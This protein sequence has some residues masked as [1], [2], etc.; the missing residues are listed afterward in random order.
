MQ[1]IMQHTADA[2]GYEFAMNENTFAAAT[3]E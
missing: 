3:Q 1:S 2:T